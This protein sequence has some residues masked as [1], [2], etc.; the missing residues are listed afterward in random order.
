MRSGDAPKEAN[1]NG[2][3]PSPRERRAIRVVVADDHPV[4][5]QGL[6]QILADTPDITVAGEASTAREVLTEVRRHGCDVVLLDLSMPGGSGL[7]VI[8]QIKAESPVTRILVLSMHAEDQYAVRVLRLGASGYLTKECAPD[9]L[10][11]AIRRVHGGG[12]YVSQSLAETLVNH[13]DRPAQLSPHQALSDREY[14][15]LCLIAKGLR[16]PQI[17]R[18]LRLSEKTVSTYRTRVM[19]KMHLKTTADLIRYAIRNHLVD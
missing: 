19:Q 16:G 1:A 3:A 5:R 7:D 12:R 10:V 8:Q 2:R 6:K 18:E 11:N 17:A 15:V 14:Q 13:L 9:E 4:V